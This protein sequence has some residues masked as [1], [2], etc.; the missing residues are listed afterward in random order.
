MTSR[1]RNILLA[2]IAVVFS[3]NSFGFVF[4]FLMERDSLKQKAFEELYKKEAHDRIEILTFSLSD[5]EDGNIV[6]RI[7]RKE[8][9][10]KGKMFDIVKEEIGQGTIV[11]YCIHDEKEDKLEK[12]FAKNV[13]K[14]ADDKCLTNS[15]MQFNNQIHF[16]EFVNKPDISSPI[17]KNIFYSS[18]QANR[19]PNISQVLTPPPKFSLC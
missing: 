12:E 1:I 14:N 3:F 10:F 8:I 7:N 2:L 11:F 15:Q 9:R 13:Q 6:Q 18:Y 17:K 4:H 19:L 16:V 5:Y